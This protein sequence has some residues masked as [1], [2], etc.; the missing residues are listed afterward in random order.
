MK[1]AV[2]FFAHSYPSGLVYHL[3]H[4][5]CALTETP[6]PIP[7]ELFI[8][9]EKQEQ[10]AGTW[11]MLK[12]KIDSRHVVMFSNYDDD[13]VRKLEQLLE[14]FDKL[15]I[16]FGGG[17]HQLH[18]L[19]AIRRKYGDRIKLVA[20]THAFHMGTWKRFPSSL[21]QFLLYWRHVDHVV[22]QTPYTARKFFGGGWLLHRGRASI[23]PLGVEHFDRNESESRPQEPLGNPDLQALL[24]DRTFFNIVYLATFKPGKGHL[25][26]LRTLGGVLCENPKIRVFLLGDGKLLEKVR[27]VVSRL[28]LERQVICPGRIQRKH[29]PWVLA[30][31]QLALVISRGETFGHCFLE[32]AFAGLPVLGT[33]VG[34]GEYLIQ[35]MQ[36][37]IG[38]AYGDAKSLQDAVRF[39]GRHPEEGRRMGGQLKHACVKTFTHDSIARA[40]ACLYKRL[41]RI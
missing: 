28:H 4:L 32:P 19:I 3:A 15:L 16:H 2:L 25:W 13:V 18:P 30:Q 38:F 41:L 24:S 11:E 23:I 7:C 6:A 33:R 27:Q 8:C 22:F 26:L 29:I 37:G 34:V 12:S 36:T 10:Y 40:H 21:L 31:Q 14:R 17:F 5:A 20:T 35:D 9:S 39:F 1:T